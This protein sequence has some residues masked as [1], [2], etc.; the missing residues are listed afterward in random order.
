M[1]AEDLVQRFEGVKRNGRGWIA[2]CPAH[3][4][5]RASL[6]VSEGDDGRVL[7]HCHAGCSTEAI[8]ATLGLAVRDLF[9]ER[10]ANARARRRE[11]ATYDYTNEHG[12]LIYQVVR[13]DPR[14]SVSANP[15]LP[16]AGPG[17]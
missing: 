1:N 8:L 14:I 13:F 11:A 9:P 16:A 17:T 5:R 7:A 2:R 3:D 4:D 15:T 12:A 6:S 10:A